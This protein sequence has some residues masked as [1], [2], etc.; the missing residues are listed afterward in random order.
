MEKWGKKGEKEK[1]SSSTLNTIRTDV[2]ILVTT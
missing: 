1:E 2:L